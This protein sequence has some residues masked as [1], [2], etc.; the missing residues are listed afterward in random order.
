MFILVGWIISTLLFSFFIL[1]NFMIH[2]LPCPDVIRISTST[3]S[4]FEQEGSRILC[5]QSS[6][7]V[8]NVGSFWLTF[9]Y[10]FCLFFSFSNFIPCRG[11]LV[12]VVE[13]VFVTDILISSLHQESIILKICIKLLKVEVVTVVRILDC[14]VKLLVIIYICPKHFYLWLDTVIKRRRRFVCF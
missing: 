4:F 8:L 6:V 13:L 7:N 3:V 9:Q 12:E 11:C 5:L 14:N 10:A 2:L 1:K